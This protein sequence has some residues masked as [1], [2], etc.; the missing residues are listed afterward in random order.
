MADA[1]STDAV[2][3]RDDYVLFNLIFV[4]GALSATSMSA[5]MKYLLTITV[6]VPMVIA[7]YHYCVRS[8][9]FGR[10]LRRGKKSAF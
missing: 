10:F 7:T 3:I 2:M 9:R 1:L 4:A 8:T 6:A 5:T